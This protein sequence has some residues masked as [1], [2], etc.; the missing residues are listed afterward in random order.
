[1]AS[2][3]AAEKHGLFGATRNG[4]DIVVVVG[5][6]MEG[7]DRDALEAFGDELGTAEAR[8]YPGPTRMIES[9]EY[10]PLA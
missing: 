1:M 3:V 7:E 8:R 10:D 6:N 5:P 9:D 4:D 2:I